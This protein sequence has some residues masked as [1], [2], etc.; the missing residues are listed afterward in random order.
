MIGPA[1]S[2]S[3]G[4][5]WDDWNLSESVHYRYYKVIE[6]RVEGK[7]AWACDATRVGFRIANE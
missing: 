3:R 6:M 4:E 5:G 2:R 1:T 7:I